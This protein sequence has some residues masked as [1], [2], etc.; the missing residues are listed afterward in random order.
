MIK[1]KP[2][3]SFAVLSLLL[4]GAYDWWRLRPVSYGP[5]VVAPASPRQSPA[6]DASSFVHKGFTI[7]PLAEFSVEARVLSRENYRFDPTSELSPIDLALGWGPM[8]DE[9]VLADLDI[10]QSGRWFTWRAAQLPL[11]RQLIEHNAAN[12]HIVPAGRRVE[13]QLSK[14]RPGEVVR[15]QG[16]L[17]K[18]EKPGLNPWVSSLSRYDTGAGACEIVWVESLRTLSPQ[19]RI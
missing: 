1:L 11:P 10:E 4:Y 17:I 7:T 16:Y 12:M 13:R 18:A 6:R 5:G 14:L 2:L 19:R 9:T 3:L 15:L 8:S